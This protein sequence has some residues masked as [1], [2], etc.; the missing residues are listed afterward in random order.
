MS[1]KDLTEIEDVFVFARAGR[2]DT[3]GHKSKTVYLP[4]SPAHW[5]Y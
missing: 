1:M 5:K 3:Q 2:K 4:L